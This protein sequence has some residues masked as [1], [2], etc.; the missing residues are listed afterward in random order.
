M[1]LRDYQTAASLACV[2]AWK[3]CQST[4]VVL[5]TGCGKTVL[6]ADIVRRRFPART[7]FLAHR[8]ELIFQ[9]KRTIERMTGFSVGVEMAE[10]RLDEQN[11][12]LFGHS[13]V[14]VS[15]IQTQNAGG[16]GAGRMTKFDPMQFGLLVIDEA[17]HA[18]ADSYRRV[19]DYYRQNPD[20]KVLGITAT[21][22]R[23]DEE[24]LG[25][26]YESVAFDYE[27]TDAIAQGWLVPVH[28]RMVTV[29]T[30]DF[31]GMRTTAGDLNGAELAALMEDERNLQEIA[32]PTIDIAGDRKTLV[33]A[34]S[35]KHAER[36]AEI[37]NRHRGGSAAWVCGKTPTDARRQT[38]ADYH[39]GKVQ[40]L[41]NVGC[42]TEGFDEPAVGLVVMGRPTKSRSLY[43]QMAGRGTRPLPGV[44]DGLDSITE[45]RAA[46][47]ASAK[48]H[49]EILDFC[50]NSGRHKLI[51]TADILGGKVSEEAAEAVREKLKEA[52]GPVD[53]EEAMALA[54]MEVKEKK[55]REAASRVKLVAKAQYH[56]QTVDPF[57]VFNV[58][59]R[60]ERAWDAGKS[61]TEKQ[62]AVLDKAK[63]PYAGLSYTLQKQLLDEQFRRYDNGLATY[64]QAKVLQKYNFPGD[65]SRDEAK[66]LIDAIVANDWKRP[67]GLEVQN[68][69]PF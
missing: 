67:A 23:A 13:H 49:V 57:D 39:E 33:F 26:I 6:A 21:P 35:V 17:H 31:S 16:D 43:A 5:P 34:A 20:L 52:G 54:E 63:I 4:L 69:P 25:Q 38:L 12:G 32:A 28:Q 44:V 45:R 37:F 24:A 59:P 36:L 7:M 64:G 61:L 8:E 60:R 9:G 58:P 15:S 50:G 2:D 27:V 46:I 56:A 30:L 51:S 41:V 1:Q 66:R 22:D 62:L 3:A 47:A 48:P 10:Q 68:A 65:V 55:R 42:L 53:M 29:G 11:S 18:T 19:I 14:V 40:F